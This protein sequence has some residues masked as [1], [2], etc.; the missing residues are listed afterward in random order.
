MKQKIGAVVVL[1]NPSIDFINNI[2]SYIDYVSHLIII[3]NSENPNTALSE[4]FSQYQNAT[5][6]LNNENSGVAKALN[7]GIK[8]L[9]LKNYDW[10]L[11]MDQDSY[12]EKDMISNYIEDLNEITDKTKIAV[13]GPAIANKDDNKISKK[14]TEVTNLITSGSFINIETFNEIGG[15]TEKLFIDEVDHD[16]CFRAKI[17]GYAILRFEHISLCHTLGEKIMI[18]TVLGKRKVKTFHP[19]LRLYYIVRNCCYIFSIYKKRFPEEIKFKRR[20][21]L[22]RIKNNLLYG[23]KRFSSLRNIILGYI[24]YKTNRFG[25]R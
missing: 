25:K 11:T 15:Y 24:H 9:A 17:S 19:P 3:D 22:V 5:L 10:A 21:L 20:D 7:T 2:Y 8:L 1:Y 23:T 12:F 4:S 16:Y 18:K 14:I 13:I 6:I